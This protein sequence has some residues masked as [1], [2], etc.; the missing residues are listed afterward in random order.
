MPSHLMRDM[1]EWVN[2]I[3]TVSI[4]LAK[5]QP[6]KWAWALTSKEEVLCMIL[7]CELEFERKWLVVVV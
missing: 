1:H 6:G 3:P 2:V 5:P 4:Y 7:V